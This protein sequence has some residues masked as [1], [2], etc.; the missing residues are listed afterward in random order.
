MQS[1]RIEVGHVHQVKAGNIVGAIANEAGIES[2][3]IGRIAI[4]DDFS[5][6]DLPARMPREVFFALKNVRVAGR[7]LNMSR[8]GGGPPP[9]TDKR[10]TKKRNFRDRPDAPITQP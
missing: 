8:V 6:V 2:Q 7:P 10:F 5:I 1:F 3:F 4:F 9:K